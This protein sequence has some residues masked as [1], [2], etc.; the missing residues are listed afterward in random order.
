MFDG[1]GIIANN[2]FPILLDH[3]SYPTGY[4][5]LFMEVIINQELPALENEQDFETGQSI[6]SF[7]RSPAMESPHLSFPHG[8]LFCCSSVK[9]PDATSDYDLRILKFITWAKSV[10]IEAEDDLP[11][12]A[13][14][15]VQLLRDPSFAIKFAIL[16]GAWRDSGYYA[17]KEPEGESEEFERVAEL[18]LWQDNFRQMQVYLT[19]CEQVYVM[20]NLESKVKAGS[21]QCSFVIVTP[22]DSTSTFC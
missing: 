1:L 2:T 20:T 16:D 12:P 15:D 11:N 9:G 19:L 4:N 3:S 13:V 7:Q 6:L 17:P 14:F 10:F 22:R 5:P 18:H 8:Q 21:L